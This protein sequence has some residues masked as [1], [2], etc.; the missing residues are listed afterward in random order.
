MITLAFLAPL[1]C[2]ALA[3]RTAAVGWTVATVLAVCATA[4]LALARHWILT[5]AT[6]TLLV[7]CTVASVAVLATGLAADWRR[8]RVLASPGTT[9]GPLGV[10]GVVGLTFSVA[11]GVVGLCGSA[12]MA[13]VFTMNGGLPSTPQASQVLPLP[14]GLT[15][16]DDTDQGCS[17]GSAT[18]CG[19]MIQVRA[20]AG[21]AGDETVRALRDHLTRTRGWR[22]TPDR[23][24]GWSGCRREGVLLDRRQVCVEV[25]PQ[26]GRDPVSVLLQGEST[27]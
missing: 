15:V 19:R 21:Q 27:W 14:D 5:G 24:S 23:G 25:I 18:I 9:P 3:A 12:L 2:W 10:R 6:V 22:L 11:Y 26:R 20:T 16:T 17:G 1:G 8:V 7:A 4:E 13:F